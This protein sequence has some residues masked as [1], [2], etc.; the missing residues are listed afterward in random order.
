M[1]RLVLAVAVLV[2]LAAAAFLWLSAPPA[3]SSL[4]ASGATS[5]APDATAPDA[6][7]PD[8]AGSAD[9]AANSFI[10]CPGDP[11]CP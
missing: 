4:D 11:R 5:A 9:E 6:A 3:A 1:S 8:A 2:V 7:A 10:V